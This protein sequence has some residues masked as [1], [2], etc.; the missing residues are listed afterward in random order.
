MYCGNVST[1]SKARAYG[2]LCT[3]MAV[4]VV[5]DQL[6]RPRILVS[7][8]QTRINC[9]VFCLLSALKNAC[10]S[11]NG[12]WHMRPPLEHEGAL[13]WPME[14]RHIS[15]KLES[16]KIETHRSAASPCHYYPRLWMHEALPL[17]PRR[18]FLT[19]TSFSSC[20]WLGFHL[21]E[22]YRTLGESPRQKR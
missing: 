6:F 17:L 1:R 19:W 2:F 22:R 12:T 20:G 10:Q 3:L 14:S 21:T 15:Q 4:S 11:S 13:Q 8:F 9:P 16:G 5:F 18:Y 7:C